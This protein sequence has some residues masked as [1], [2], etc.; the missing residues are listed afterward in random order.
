MYEEWTKEELISEIEN[1]KRRK[2][3]GLVWEA[4]DEDAVK[5]L[6]DNYPYLEEDLSKQILTDS[7]KPT[8][9]IIEGD[10]YHSLSVLNYTH[11]EKIDVIYIDPP[12]NT[13]SRDWKYNNDYVDSEDSFRHSKWISMMDSRLKAS[14][15]LLKED[16]VLIC[17]IDEHELPRTLLLLEENYKNYHIHSVPVVHNPKGTQYGQF[18]YIH[19]Y[20]IFVIP[21][22]PK[23][24]DKNALQIKKDIEKTRED[25]SKILKSSSDEEVMTLIKK[26]FPEELI[27]KRS[28]RNSNKLEGNNSGARAFGITRTFFPIIIEDNNIL[29][30]GDVCEDNFHPTK[31]TIKEG[32][33]YYIYPVDPG[34]NERKWMWSKEVAEKNIDLL[35]IKKLG[36][37]S[38]DIHRAKEYITPKSIFSGSKYSASE[39]GTK[40]LQNIFPELSKDEQFNY[41]KSIHLVM[42][43]ISLFIKDKKDAL[44]LDF[45]AGSGTTGHAVLEMNKEDGGNRQFILCTNNENNIAEEVT[46]QRVKK[47][48]EGYKGLDQKTYHGLGGNLRYFKT[49][50][51]P[52]ENTDS[53]IKNYADKLVETLKIKEDSFE[54]Y[55]VTDDLKIYKNIENYLVIIYDDSKIYK[56]KDL[57]NSLDKKTKIYSFSLSNEDLSDYFEELEIDAEYYSFPIPAIKS[58]KKEYK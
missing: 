57:I 2:E 17:A 47:V 51:F 58:L 22:I 39:H 19:E 32:N 14:R 5:E 20:A 53:N 50:L 10:N 30:I 56:N 29:E 54:E 16:G 8:N 6:R 34:G 55:R 26:F 33:R 13:G 42:D 40:L 36:K 18:S 21:D 52:F 11:R 48:I 27:D 35:S 24:N 38:F 49:N 28:L 43:C 7:N 1:L 44:V 12:Y 23:Y 46:Y 37:D 25:I 41:P 3:Y 31:A 9:L 4:N 15:G 45:F